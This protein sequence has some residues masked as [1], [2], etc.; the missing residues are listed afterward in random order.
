MERFT[1]LM[2]SDNNINHTVYCPITSNFSRQ[3]IYGFHFILSQYKDLHIKKPLTFVTD[4]L[5][6]REACLRTETKH[7]SVSKSATS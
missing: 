2:Y 6:F 4:I 7:E 5:C 1:R 3:R